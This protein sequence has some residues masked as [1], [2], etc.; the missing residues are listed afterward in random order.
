MA[1][2]PI[3]RQAESTALIDKLFGRHDRLPNTPTLARGHT[4]F[5][6]LFLA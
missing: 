1:R 4:G 6:G 2:Y 3:G 5:M